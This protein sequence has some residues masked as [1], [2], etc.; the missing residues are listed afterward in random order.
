MAA[1][2]LTRIA[3]KWPSLSS[4]S[5]ASVT[6][7]RACASDRKASVRVLIHFTGRPM[8]FDGVTGQRRFIEHR[9]LHAEAAADVDADHA[10]FAFRDVQHL[11]D[12]VAIGVRA[13]HRRVDDVAVLRRQIDADGAARLHRRRGHAVDDEAAFGDMRGLG[14]GGVGRRLVADQLDEGDIVGALVVDARRRPASP[15]RRSRRRRAVLRNRPATSSAASRAC[16]G[17]SATT[18]ATGSP[19]QRTRSSA[20]TG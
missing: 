6:L 16:A 20:S 14:E 18:K 15:P 17:V 9:R 11:G 13:L 8:S 1:M 5:S 3:R 19:T 2:V 7:S 10:H 12:L 4:A